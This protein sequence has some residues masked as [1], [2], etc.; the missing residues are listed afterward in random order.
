MAIKFSDLRKLMLMNNTIVTVGRVSVDLYGVES[1]AAFSNEQTFSKSVGGSPSNVA[2]AAAK[3]G[4]HAVLLTK[5]GA[6]PLGQYIVNKLNNWGVDTKYV[7]TEP[8]GLTPV[9]LAALDPPEDPKLIFHRQPNAPDTTINSDSVPKDLIAQCA[10]F[11][12]SGCALAR[13]ETAKSSLKWLTQRNRRQHTVID[14]DYRPSFWSSMQ[15]AGVAARAAIANCTVV[16]GNRTECEMAIGLTE[17]NAIADKLLSDGVE[18]AIVKLGADGVMLA[19][20]K[21]RIRIAPCKIK[22]V[23]GLGSGDAFGGALAHGL[24]RGWS[25]QQIGE[26]ANA[27]GAY[28]ATKLTCA[29]AM[30][31]EPM[32]RNF[33]TEQEKI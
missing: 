2:V 11:W 20:T 33:I 30:P 3:L 32:L 14:L 15:E 16:V 1:G 22:L 10:V 25:L 28:V 7:S 31:T 26:F 4:N 27:A 9:V 17:P 13:G 5:V 18:I 12:M 24:L 19:T 29:D 23:C 6:D 21:E 8:N